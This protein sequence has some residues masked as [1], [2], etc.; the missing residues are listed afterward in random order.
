MTS[1]ERKATIGRT[2]DNYL[3]LLLLITEVVTNPTQA[4]IDAAVTADGTD[5]RLKYRIDHS[6]DG[7]SYNWTGWQ[8]FVGRQ[9]EQLRK[10]ELTLA[11]PYEVR[12]RAIS[13]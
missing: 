8:E 6:L 5:S 1:A 11:G 3:R 9:L 2:I 13:R 12:S 7:E 10:L 4:N